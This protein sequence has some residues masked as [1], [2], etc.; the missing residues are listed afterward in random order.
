MKKY[1][2]FL[3]VPLL[4]LDQITKWL[5][6][7]NFPDS[8]NEAVA[9]KSIEVI[10]GFFNIVRVHNTGMAWGIMN[11]AQHANWFFGAIGL[12]AITAI[13]ILW[14]K[15][16]FPDRISKTAAAL[17]ISGIV[18]N[19]TDRLLPGRGYVVDFLDFLPPFYGKLFPT[20]GGH[21]PSFNVADSCICIAAGLLILSAFRQ[22]SELS[23][24]QQENR[25]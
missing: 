3:S 11:G 8:Y 18:G 12:V 17:L 14:K 24:Q 10:P 23:K 5:I 1:L 16:A 22:P 7:S 13:T 15:G 2:L 20:S 6:V 21:F 19:L 25:K 9:P 4:I